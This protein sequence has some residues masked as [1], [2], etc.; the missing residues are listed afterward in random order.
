MTRIVAVLGSVTPPGRLFYALN[1][2]L[3]DVRAA[4]GSIEAELIDLA[5]VRLGFADGG[6][7]DQ[8]SDDS[9]AVVAAL[10]SADAVLLASP[11]YR[12]S[13]TGA[14]EESARPHAH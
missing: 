14:S 6:P 4:D 2:A 10:A 9:P 5:A 8:L 13:L 3:A 12:A 11:V 1:G 7:L